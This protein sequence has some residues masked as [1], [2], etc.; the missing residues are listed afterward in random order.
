MSVEASRQDDAVLIE[1]IREG[2]RSATVLLTR[3][4]VLVRRVAES[5]FDEL[6]DKYVE[7]GLDADDIALHIEREFVPVLRF[8]DT[9]RD[10]ESLHDVDEYI[11]AAIRKLGL[12]DQAI[13]KAE[14]EERDMDGVDGA[15][16]TGGCDTGED[17]DDQR[18]DA[19]LI[20]MIRDGGEARQELMR[21]KIVKGGVIEKVCK[22]LWS[23]DEFRAAYRAQRIERDDLLQSICEH[24]LS[25]E[26]FR[27]FDISKVPERGVDGYLYA[28]LR[29]S[30]LPTRMTKRIGGTTETI[31]GGDAP[32]SES[33]DLRVS[34]GTKPVKLHLLSSIAEWWGGDA[35]AALEAVATVFT[36]SAPSP[37]RCLGI[38]HIVRKGAGIGTPGAKPKR[39]ISTQVSA[40]WLYGRRLLLSCYAHA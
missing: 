38:R 25:R 21:R 33:D 37:C 28:V 11:G 40:E 16:G 10:D 15:S 30:A 24:L 1:R 29:T 14:P 39:S 36:E 4:R 34:C 31:W 7:Q 6:R 8:A 27:S 23:K 22:G 35:N 5:L 20:D 12:P 3:K 9:D 18:D 19:L 17:M 2:V 13:R 26:E 32:D